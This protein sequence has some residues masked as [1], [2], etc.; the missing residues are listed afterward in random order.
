M[1]PDFLPEYEG[2]KLLT[3]HICVANG[4]VRPSPSGEEAGCKL[5]CDQ[6]GNCEGFRYSQSKNECSLMRRCR[7]FTPAKNLHVY[8]R[9]IGIFSFYI[10]KDAFQGREFTGCI[11]S[12]TFMTLYSRIRLNSTNYSFLA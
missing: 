12:T 11:I 5:L 10:S 3:N 8:I 6:Q 9:L 7:Y 1:V 4:W 2:Y